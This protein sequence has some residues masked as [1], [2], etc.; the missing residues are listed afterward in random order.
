MTAS[1]RVGLHIQVF[2]AFAARQVGGHGGAAAGLWPV[3][4]PG[5]ASSGVP[6]GTI[7]EA[8]I[9]AVGSPRYPRAETFGWTVLWM[10]VGIGPA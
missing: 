7:D 6:N 10:S 1:D 4:L 9:L 2:Y 5:R 8:T 3:R